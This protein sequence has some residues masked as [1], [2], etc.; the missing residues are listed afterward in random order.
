MNEESKPEI[1]FT[2]KLGQAGQVLGIPIGGVKALIR[3]KELEQLS[4]ANGPLVVTQS[5]VEYL[6]RKAFRRRWPF[7]LGEV[8]FEEQREGKKKRTRES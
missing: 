1:P 8:K 3:G 5:V 2:M 7:R 4:D 6:G